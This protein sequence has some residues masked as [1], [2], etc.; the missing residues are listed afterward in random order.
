VLQKV[1]Q[2]KQTELEAVESSKTVKKYA[3]QIIEYWFL[4][5]MFFDEPHK[6]RRGSAGAASSFGA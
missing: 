1:L 3:E 6:V 2:E 4:P 5:S